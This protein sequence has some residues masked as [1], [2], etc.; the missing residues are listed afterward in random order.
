MASSLPSWHQMH[1]HLRQSYIQINPGRIKD[2]V[3]DLIR[4][5]HNNKMT[6]NALL[7][8]CISEIQEA[9]CTASALLI[10]LILDDW[11]GLTVVVSEID[12]TKRTP[13]GGNTK[14]FLIF[15]PSMSKSP[16]WTAVPYREVRQVW[17]IPSPRH[18]YPLCLS[19]PLWN[20]NPL[21][22]LTYLY[23]T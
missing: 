23:P 21:S 3:G 20:S 2:L 16:Y 5:I 6:I 22:T 12:C 15:F 13:C 7:N 10:K 9:W 18:T 8:V 17:A 19:P 14:P 1:M 11:L 4:S